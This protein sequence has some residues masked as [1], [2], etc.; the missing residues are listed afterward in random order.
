MYVCA[1][2]VDV[3]FGFESCVRSCVV[4]L[5]VCVVLHSCM[6]SCAVLFDVCFVSDNVNIRVLCC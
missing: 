3:C 4:L 6:P 5:I 2:L 1:V